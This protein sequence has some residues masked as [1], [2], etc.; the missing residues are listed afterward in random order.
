MDQQEER[1][2]KALIA[3]R[4]VA[5][6][7]GEEQLTVLLS[8]LEEYGIVRQVGCFMSDNA[9]TNDTLCRSVSRHLESKEK[10][11]WN[12]EKQRLRCIGHVNNLAVQAFLFQNVFRIEEL[13]S[14]DQEEET[15]E[16]NNIADQ[17]GRF[18]LIGPLGKLHNIVICVRSSSQ[19]TKEFRDIIG[20][21]VPLDNRTRWNSWYQM[22][23]VAVQ[24]SIASAIDIFTKNHFDVLQ[25]DYL[26][27]DDWTR[28]RTIK[29]FLQPFA[30]ATLETQGTAGTIDRVLFTMDVLT[31]WFDKAL[32]R[33]LLLTI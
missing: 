11:T 23:T 29:N 18:R 5:S 8:V 1:Q 25:H 14:Y 30:R 7:A 6:H 31:Q 27:S 12:T 2:R 10:I 33:H 20:Q 16:V 9:S 3:L 26:S 19:R 21:M 22:L 17:Q 13:E 28:L 32:V 15:R 24:S 4:P